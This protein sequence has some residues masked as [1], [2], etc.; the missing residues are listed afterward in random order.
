[1]WSF[2]AVKL[3]PIRAAGRI[4]LTKDGADPVHAAGNYQLFRSFEA[5]GGESKSPVVYGD[6]HP[7]ESTPRPVLG[8]LYDLKFVERV[9][10]EKVVDAYLVLRRKNGGSSFDKARQIHLGF[11][12]NPEGSA[13]TELELDENLV[14]SEIV[15]GSFLGRWVVHAKAIPRQAELV[16]GV[17]CDLRLNPGVYRNQI[18]DPYRKYTCIAKPEAETACASNPVADGCVPPAPVLKSKLQTAF[19]VGGETEALVKRNDQV[20]QFGENLS[21][22]EL[23]F[24]SGIQSGSDAQNADFCRDRFYAMARTMDDFVH[25]VC[26]VT[27]ASSGSVR[28]GKIACRVNV[29]IN[30][31]IA[32]TEKPCNVRAVFVTDKGEE[33]QIVQVI[34]R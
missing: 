8:Y 29:A 27:P 7:D 15:E 4:I 13:F 28:N 33:D 5:G 19:E 34:H 16:N 21:A 20:Y 3:G 25:P 11:G 10:S 6:F 24:V 18:A 1:M 9:G 17:E 2:G 31:P 23:L 22:G 30:S 14:V 12:K 26:E 32:Y